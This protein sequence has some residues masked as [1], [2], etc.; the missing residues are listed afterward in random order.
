M[1]MKNMRYVGQAVGWPVIFACSALV[2]SAQMPG[3]RDAGGYPAPTAELERGRTVYV[4]S[5]C[6]F[7][8]GIDLTGAAMGAANLMTSPLVGRDEN[9]NL[10]GAVVRAGLPNLQT[11]MPQY[12]DYTD[13]QISDLA[14]YIH[15]LRQQ[16]RYKELMALKTDLSGDAAAGR[17]YFQGAG[18][19]STCHSPSGD[20]GGIA[21]KYS[22]EILRARFLR[23]GAAFASEG[24][25]AGTIAHLKLLEK[26]S[27]DDVQNLVTYLMTME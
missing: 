14:A 23:P 8:H 1:G 26:Y 27:N 22:P 21:K 9:G 18:R 12:S 16:G 5:S 7:C 10:I 20:L 15:Y 25:S 4:L 17:A 6:H 13:Q 11:A 2:A 3:K 19:C 24:A